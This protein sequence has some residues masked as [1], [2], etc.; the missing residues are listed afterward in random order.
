MRLGGGVY[1]L[2]GPLD[3]FGQVWFFSLWCW[4]RVRVEVCSPVRWRFFPFDIFYPNRRDQK[5]RDF[6]ISE[7]RDVSYLFP[8]D[9]VQG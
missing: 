2:R 7:L 3:I 1:S 4:W 5:L 9:Q 6:G 8:G